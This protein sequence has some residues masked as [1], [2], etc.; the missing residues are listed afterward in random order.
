[1]QKIHFSINYLVKIWKQPKFVAI[2]YQLNKMHVYLKIHNTQDYYVAIKNNGIVLYNFFI[3]KVL[4][5]ME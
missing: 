2:E 1:M 4:R 5:G 3:V